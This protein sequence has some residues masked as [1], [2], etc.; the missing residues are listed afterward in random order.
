LSLESEAREYDVLVTTLKL[1]FESV[2]RPI[3]A[4]ETYLLTFYDNQ[5]KQVTIMENLW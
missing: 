3:R 4:D 5:R 1:F 2:L